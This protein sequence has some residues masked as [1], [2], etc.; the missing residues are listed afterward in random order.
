MTDKSFDTR[1]F[2]NALGCF[3]T[4][5]TVI[6]T[7]GPD[8]KPE[9]LTANS[10]GAVS[11]EPPLVHWC[12]GKKS[13]LLEIF[14]NTSHFTVNVL[15][16]AQRDISNQ[17]ATPAE[18][19]FAG[20]DWQP[21]LGDAPVLAGSLAVFECRNEKHYEGGDHLIFLGAVENYSH[22]DG[23]PL[24][25]NAGSYGIAR[26]HPDDYSPKPDTVDFED[27]MLW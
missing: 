21:G 15:S 8:N 17:F 10:F 26:P 1:A 22:I 6:T 19:K 24:L 13:G 9:G 4:G 23:T 20:V 5:I 7:M 11:L 27:L 18:D 3:P 12:L 14:Q 16:D 25:F 2:R